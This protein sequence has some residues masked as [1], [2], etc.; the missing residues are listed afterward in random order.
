[1]T[2]PLFVP[3]IVLLLVTAWLVW[4]SARMHDRLAALH[5]DVSEITALLLEMLEDAD[6]PGPVTWGDEDAEYAMGVPAAYADSGDY[7][8]HGKEDGGGNHAH[9]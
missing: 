2:N 5:L 3:V 6:D 9:G 1:M 7:R 4:L 8:F